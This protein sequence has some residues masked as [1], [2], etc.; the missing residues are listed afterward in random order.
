MCHNKNITLDGITFKNMKYGH[1]IEMDA[2]KNVTVNNCTFTGY[3]ASK[4]H[5]S[6]AINFDT[7]D[8]KTKGF[9]HDWSKYDCTANQNVKITKCIFSNL[10]KAIGTHQYSVKKYHTGITI[11]DCTIKSVSRL[12]KKSPASIRSG[13][14]P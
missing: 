5:T 4:R 13:G 2:S 1:F 6:E 12:S 10:E 14:L 3:K 7:P 11:S 9:T 8:K